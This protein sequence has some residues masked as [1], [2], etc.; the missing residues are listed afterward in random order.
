MGVFFR[1]PFASTFG[2]NRN[3]YYGHRDDW[4][5]PTIVYIRELLQLNFLVLQCTL[6]FDLRI[7]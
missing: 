1:L 2:S 4:K 3:C 7:L 6:C 5:K